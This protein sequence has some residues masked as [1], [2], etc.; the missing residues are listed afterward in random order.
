[1][2]RK[3]PVLRIAG[4]HAIT[5]QAACAVITT[6]TG[7]CSLFP[8]ANCDVRRCL[9]AAASG[10]Q[11]RHSS[12]WL[13]PSPSSRLLEL[14]LPSQFGRSKG[15]PSCQALCRSSW[16]QERASSPQQVRTLPPRHPYVTVTSPHLFPLQS[17]NSRS[18]CPC[19]PCAQIARHSTTSLVLPSP[20][21]DPQTSA[22]GTALSSRVSA[23]PST[24]C[25]HITWLPACCSH[26]HCFHPTTHS[27]ARRAELSTSR[28]QIAL[29]P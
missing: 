3:K 19:C 5:I 9:F 15:L 18:L 11:A 6:A 16:P 23:N 20:S 28:P 4:P 22:D 27:T 29:H 7:I 17:N 25:S 8:H 12:F 2:G 21:R 14:S 13:R 24:S 10:W 1:M 26:S